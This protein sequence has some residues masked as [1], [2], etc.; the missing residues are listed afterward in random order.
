MNNELTPLLK[1]DEVLHH[2]NLS[3][4]SKNPTNF[5]TIY[6]AMGKNYPE[7]IDEM[8]LMNILRKLEKDKYI[9]AKITEEKTDYYMTY[10]GTLFD[11]VGG[12]YKENSIKES[13][14][15][16][17]TAT[18]ILTIVLAAG[19]VVASIYYLNELFNKGCCCCY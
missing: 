2:I 6:D 18:F 12:Y 11:S 15:R 3:F 5:K 13:L 8:E 14:L 10:D 17:K 16:I 7:Q 1:I 19:T 9:E 4:D